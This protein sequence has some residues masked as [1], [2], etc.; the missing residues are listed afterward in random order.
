MMSNMIIISCDS[1]EEAEIYFWY[2][3]DILQLNVPYFIKNIF[4]HSL[5]IEME[6]D[7]RYI[8][9]YYRYISV[10]KIESPDVIDVE[11]F[12]EDIETHYLITNEIYYNSMEKME[13][14]YN[15]YEIYN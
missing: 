1:F 14:L 4:E 9:M 7:L 5:C 12:F 10:L 6:D 2:F 11:Q 8:F 15:D 3:H 13:N